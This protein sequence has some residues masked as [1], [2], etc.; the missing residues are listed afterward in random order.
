MENACGLSHIRCSAQHTCHLHG[1][2]YTHVVRSP[3][4]RTR[5]RMRTTPQRLGVLA[6]W[7]AVFV[8]CQKLEPHPRS[9]CRPGPVCPGPIKPTQAETDR[10]SD[11]NFCKNH[12]PDQSNQT[13]DWHSISVN[14]KRLYVQKF[15]S[16]WHRC[17]KFHTNANG[18]TFLCIL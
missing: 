7:T 9:S 11:P 13:H 2:Y 14:N 3:N 15:S 12:Q 17:C 10:P 8:V 16:T 6:F 5:N 4:A 1:I 18:R